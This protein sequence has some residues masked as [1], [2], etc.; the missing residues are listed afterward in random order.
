MTKQAVI[1]SRF[2]PRPNAKG[3]DSCEKQEER[4]FILLDRKEYACHKRLRDEAVSGGILNRPGLLAAL[5]LLKPGWILVVDSSD[6]LA[7]NML[8]NLTIRQ[9]V[10]DA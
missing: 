4:C 3:C 6:R 8:V 2:S 7:R 10:A 5:R 1:Y 9:Q